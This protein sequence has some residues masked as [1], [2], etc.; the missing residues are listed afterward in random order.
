MK[1]QESDTVLGKIMTWLK[2]T[3]RP[4]WNI[5]SPESREIKYYLARWDSLHLRHGILYQKWESVVGDQIIW[6]LVLPKDLRLFVLKALHSSPTAG[7]LGVNKTLDRTKAR[8]CWYGMR[9]DVEHVCRTC[10]L[11]ESRK[12]PKQHYKGPLQRYTVGIPMER[13]ALDIMGPLPLRDKGNKY[14]L[15]IEDYFTKWTE[16]VPL[17]DQEAI[18]VANA[19]IESFVTR[20]G[21]P[22][23][24]HSGQGTNFESNVFKEMCK[25]LGIEKTRTSPYRPQSDGMVERA[26][27]TIENMLSM[28]LEPNQ[29]D[30][31]TFNYIYR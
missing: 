2:S 27:Q 1:L 31:D 10:D 28:L 24:L 19:L 18:T 15:V 17:P 21:V 7:H 16:A 9:R 22:R 12:R 11:C 14:L 23:E 30:W 29:R 20:F 13:V 8:F 25:L 6:K 26:N 3:E 5:V 4:E